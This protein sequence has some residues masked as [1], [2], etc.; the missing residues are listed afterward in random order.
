MATH[1]SVLAWRIPGT[2]EPGGLPSMGSHR[3]GPD[4]R[5]RLKRLS[6]SS[7]SRFGLNSSS[8]ACLLCLTGRLSY[9][10]WISVY[11]SIK[12]ECSH[13]VH[14][15]C[16]GKDNCF[17]SACLSNSMQHPNLLN[18]LITISGTQNT[19]YIWEWGLGAVKLLSRNWAVRNIEITR[20]SQDRAQRPRRMCS[21]SVSDMLK[22][23][24]RGSGTQYKYLKNSQPVHGLEIIVLAWLTVRYWKEFLNNIF[25]YHLP[26]NFRKMMP[27]NKF[28]SM[29][30][31][32]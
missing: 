2:E 16:S 6:S 24:F 27:I 4:S 30:L 23:Q 32:S 14:G 28:S 29:I 31:E 19:V 26:P 12:W 17:F 13:Q 9:L 25:F 1:S 20:P 3:V 7:S 22:F 11:S 10:L 15:R 18:Q 21:F 8:T 5:T